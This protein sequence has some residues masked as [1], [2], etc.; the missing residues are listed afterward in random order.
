MNGCLGV[1]DTILVD[2]TPDLIKLVS[3]QN[4]DIYLRVEKLSMIDLNLLRHA[5][6]SISE[7]YL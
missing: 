3:H 7:R 5:S 4:K 2:D 6:P 1:A